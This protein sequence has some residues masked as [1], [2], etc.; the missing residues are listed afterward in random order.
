VT[1]ESGVGI[2]VGA[3]FGCGVGRVGWGRRQGLDGDELLGGTE[4]GSIAAIHGV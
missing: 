4:G 1:G 2:T 3:R